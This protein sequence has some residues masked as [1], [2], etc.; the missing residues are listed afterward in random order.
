MASPFSPIAMPLYTASSA[1][2]SATSTADDPVLLFHAEM[3]PSSPA[4][5]NSAAPSVG[6]A[7]VPGMTKSA[8]AL[9]IVPVGTPGS[10]ATADGILTVGCSFTPACVYNV[11]VPVPLFATHSTPVGPKASPHGLTRFGSM[12]AAPNDATS[13]TRFA[14]TNVVFVTGVTTRFVSPLLS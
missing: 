3:V 12:V 7:P 11:D 8:D 2:R 6:P 10:P 4:K 5:M 9:K 13:A 14:W 1:D